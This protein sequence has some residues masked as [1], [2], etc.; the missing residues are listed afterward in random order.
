MTE[1]AH[2]VPEGSAMAKE[3]E[4]QVKSCRSVPDPVLVGPKTAGEFKNISEEKT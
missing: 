3:T 4:V 2:N 1:D